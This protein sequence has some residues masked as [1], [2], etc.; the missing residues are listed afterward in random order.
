MGDMAHGES[1]KGH[2][3]VGLLFIGD[4]IELDLY[5]L[6]GHDAKLI[7]SS[8]NQF[9][10][11]NSNWDEIAS[12]ARAAY[13]KT[14]ELFRSVKDDS[15]AYIYKMIIRPSMTYAAQTWILNIAVMKSLATTE[16]T[17]LRRIF[18]IR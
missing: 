10:K 5:G 9:K 11:L 2:A 3:G 13:H 7:K 12:R 17:I 15:K 1:E 14:K 4:N 16:R 18:K 8:K 6:T